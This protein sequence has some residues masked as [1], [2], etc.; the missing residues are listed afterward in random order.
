[1]QIIN[2]QPIPRLLIWHHRDLTHPHPPCKLTRQHRPRQLNR[3]RRIQRIW[4]KS[5]IR[6]GDRL[7]V[8][9]LRECG[10]GDGAC[11][12]RVGVAL[13]AARGAAEVEI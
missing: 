5:E 3:P 4:H 10:Y 9:R 2:D 13:V 8:V 6:Y 1:M 11:E 7:L 12:G